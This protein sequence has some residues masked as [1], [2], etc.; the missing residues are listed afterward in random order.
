MCLLLAALAVGCQPGAS[1]GSTAAP[2]GS[3]AAPAGNSPAPASADLAGTITWTLHEE[4]DD[5]GH[6]DYTKTRS[7][8]IVI[9]VLFN[10]GEPGDWSDAGSSYSRTGSES[11]RD[12]LCTKQSSWS[13]AGPFAS[14]PEGTYFEVFVDRAEGI[15]TYDS[16]VGADMTGTATCDPT[17]YEQGAEEFFENPACGY[18]TGDEVVTGNPEGLIGVDGRTV[19]FDCTAVL[20]TTLNE[21][22]TSHVEMRVTGTLTLTP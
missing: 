16:L 22:G 19:T 18:G 14:A 5:P 4:N 10:E 11:S 15:V 9:Q 7:E 21:V 17:S 13:G 20:D 3:T 2:A 8:T 1:P 6:L 12:D